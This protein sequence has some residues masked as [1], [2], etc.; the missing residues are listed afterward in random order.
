MNLSPP[1]SSV[2]LV[3]VALWPSSS[4]PTT[5]T[6][7]P[8]RHCPLV[9]ACQERQSGRRG[10]C[11][12]CPLAQPEPDRAATVG[13]PVLL[14]CPW[15]FGGCRFRPWLRQSHLTARRRRCWWRHWLCGGRGTRSPGAWPAISPNS[16][17]GPSIG[18]A[19]SFGPSLPS[20][21]HDNCAIACA[22]AGPLLHE[23]GVPQD[24]L[25]G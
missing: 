20:G 7:G 10:R 19:S 15:A 18:S 5:A 17:A 6:P 8:I 23:S 1:W 3:V 9:P 21:H 13:L 24:S 12:G 16:C 11:P 25:G 2:G 22:T 4:P 14:P